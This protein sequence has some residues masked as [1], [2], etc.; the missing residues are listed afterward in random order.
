MSR[1]PQVGSDAGVWGQLLNDFL[2]VEHNADG[3]LR[4]GQEI[5]AAKALASTAVQ[6]VNGLPSDSMGAVTLTAGDVGAITTTTADSR[7]IQQAAIGATVAGLSGG[8]VPTGQLPAMTDSGAVHKGDL[9]LNVKDYGAKGDGATDDT[10]AIQSAITDCG[11][12]QTVFFPVGTYMISSPLYIYR[13]QTL[14]GTHSA[15]WSYDGGNPSCIKS[16]ASFSGAAMLLAQDMELANLTQEQDG[17]RVYRM[18]FDNN[19]VGTNVDCIQLIGQIR[20]FRMEDVTMSN[21]TGS[22]VHTVGYTRS[23]IGFVHP[24]GLNFSRCSAWNNINNGFSLNDITDSILF[25][26]LAVSNYANGFYVSAAGECQFFDVRATFNGAHG[27]YYTGVHTGSVFVACTTDRNNKNGFYMNATGG[28]AVILFGFQARRDGQNGLPGSG[29]GG[30]AGVC[31]QGT[32]SSTASPVIVNGLIEATGVNDDGTGMLSPQYGLTSSYCRFLSIKGDLWGVTAPWY[33]GGNNATVR[34]D[35]GNSYTTGD[36]S[37]PVR[38][39]ATYELNLQGDS[40]TA[41][42]LSTQIVGDTTPKWAIQASGQQTFF[43]DTTLYRSQ[44]KTLRTD[45]SWATGVATQTV[46]T[47]GN[48][49]IDASAGNMQVVTLSANATSASITN[50]SLGQPL[51]IQWLQDTT[52]GWTYT[53]PANCRFAAD[54]APTPTT[55]AGARD[56]VT[57]YYDGTNWIEAAQATTGSAN[58]MLGSDTPLALGTAAAGT[59]V[60]AAREDHVHPTT[61]LLSASSFV[62]TIPPPA[63][64]TGSSGV[65]VAPA[66]ADHQ[67]PVSAL[68]P[69]DHGFISWNYPPY[70]AVNTSLLSVAGTLYLCR[71]PVPTATTITNVIMYVATA[72]S[73]L[74]SNENFAGLYTASGTLLSATADQTTAWASGGIKVMA[75]HTAQAVTAGYVYVGFYANGTTLPTLYRSVSGGILNANLTAASSNW[76][77]CANGSGLTTSPPNTLGT[78][79]A[80]TVGFWAAV[81]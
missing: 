2:L 48:V 32:S 22:G 61:G 24:K 68:G 38:D 8:K 31:I 63:A 77:T 70:A 34:F 7:Y 21:G 39:L 4:C 74:V 37:S 80:Y 46:H 78:L 60:K 45:A 17:I 9:T 58:V 15:W 51:T 53:W 26:C 52:G 36:P 44:A 25:N 12:G 11:A 35:P 23:D 29:G 5:I 47:A 20:D 33:D 3:T 50:P 65:S 40:S 10:A 28:Y 42:L 19:V 72:G 64:L 71:L 67:H 79:T 43:G 66:R 30:Y 59:S 81:S 13:N 14:E 75:L 1:L 49:T 69:A 57:F 54:S 62:T 41:V 56:S 76:A 6:T 27:F 16:M 55:V 18:S 73:G